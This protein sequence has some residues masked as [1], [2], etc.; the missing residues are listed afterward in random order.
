[1]ASESGGTDS[2]SFAMTILLLFGAVAITG[3]FRSISSPQNGSC[4]GAQTATSRVS[5]L[6]GVDDLGTVRTKDTL[7]TTLFEQP[8]N[9]PKEMK[10]KRD[11]IAKQSFLAIE[12]PTR[13]DSSFAIALI[14]LGDVTAKNIHVVER[15]VQS[16]RRRGLYFGTIVI[17]TDAKRSRF[18]SL[19]NSD[20][21]IELIKVESRPNGM[22]SKRYKTE[23]L[24]LL[25]GK[26]A[27]DAVDVLLYM[28][29]DIVI[30]E[31]LHSFISYVKSMI[32][33]LDQPS[34]SNE[35][36][37]MLMFE[38]QGAA[39]ERKFGNTVYHGGVLGLHRSRSRT[40]LKEWQHLFDDRE[41]FPDRDQKALY[42][43]L[44]INETLKERCQVTRL[45]H[46]PYLLMPSKKDFKAGE[47][48]TFVHVTNG[49]RAEKIEDSLQAD[50]YR[51][52]ALVDEEYAMS[53][54]RFKVIVDGEEDGETGE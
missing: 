5:N 33:M 35:P 44:Y 36:S 6:A 13:V 15:C 40:C 9:C 1:M 4:I 16:I 52:M 42:Y 29:V 20:T 12:H 22:L 39:P 51:C 37:Y 19:L 43:M 53:M 10:R 27:L 18:N 45:D 24:D 14:A 34:H 8:K 25:D 32:N 38:E 11:V 2:R 30:A 41:R 7:N 17:V 21:N 46:R 49:Y 50:Y 23:L 31:P 3:I 26:R 28:D 47:T 48:A 54:N